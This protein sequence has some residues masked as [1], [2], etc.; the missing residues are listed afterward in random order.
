LPLLFNF[1]SLYANRRVQANQ[2]DLKLN[3]TQQLVVDADYVNMLGG[4][5]QTTEENAEALVITRKEI[6]LEV[7]GKKTKYV[8]MSGDQ[9]TEQ[10]N[11]IKT[12][13]KSFEMVEQFKYLGTT[14]KNQNSIHEESKSR[15]KSGNA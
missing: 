1:A 2:E 8:V 3:G 12:G 13:N 4:S 7:N 5:T 15:L 6:G 11:N 10:N 14:L 9:N